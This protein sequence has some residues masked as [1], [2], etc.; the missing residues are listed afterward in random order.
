MNLGWPHVWRWMRA[1]FAKAPDAN[2]KN[3]N[4]R[5]P[6]ATG[7]AASEAHSEMHTT[8]PP[9]PCFVR[10]APSLCALSYEM[11]HEGSESLSAMSGNDNSLL[12]SYYSGRAPVVLSCPHDGELAPP[13]VPERKR[14]YLPNFTT[15]RDV[16]TKQITYALAGEIHRQT[17][18]SPMVVVAEFHRRYIDANRPRDEAYEHRPASKHYT[19]FHRRLREATRRLRQGLLLDIHGT[20]I[21]AFDVYLGTVGGTSVANLWVARELA[22]ALGAAGFRVGIDH[23]RLSGGWITQLYSWINPAIDAIQIELTPWVRKH[24]SAEV[25]AALG[26]AV[27]NHTQQL[28][29]FYTLAKIQ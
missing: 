4:L 17:G 23:P 6:K 28:Q 25:V 22:G 5:S 3:K 20:S 9:T 27:A 2:S 19:E 21:K 8:P 1:A 15:L 13:G 14:T 12:V 18:Q 11:N 24:A 7:A 26:A 29:R 16:G 10:A